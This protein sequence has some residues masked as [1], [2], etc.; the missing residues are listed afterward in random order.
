M[1]RYFTIVISRY[2]SLWWVIYFVVS[3][4]FA[5]NL[6]NPFEFILHTAARMVILKFEFNSVTML[7]KTLIGFSVKI[8]NLRAGPTSIGPACSVS[9]TSSLDLHSPLFSTL[10]T[11]LPVPQTHQSHPPPALSAWKALLNFSSRTPPLL[12]PPRLLISEQASVPQGKTPL[13]SH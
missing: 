10:H 2:H 4:Y 1:C 12:P 3:D 5:H 13:A 8:C 11:R 6:S 9:S 7:K